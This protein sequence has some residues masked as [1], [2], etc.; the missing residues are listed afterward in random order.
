MP[1]ATPA[2]HHIPVRRTARYYTLGDTS[3]TPRE[4]WIV[5]HGH[6]QLAGAFIRYFGDLEDGG[7]LVVA[8]EALSRYYL[9]PIDSAPASERGVGATWMT[10]EDRVHEID[11]YL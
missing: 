9:V 10:R 8:P 4:L 2:E 5:L 11:D 7:T 6:G 1:V 3:T